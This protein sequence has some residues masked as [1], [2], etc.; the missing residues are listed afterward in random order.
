MV[1]CAVMRRGCTQRERESCLAHRLLSAQAPLAL[2]SVPRCSVRCNRVLRSPLSS[3]GQIAWWLSCARCAVWPAIRCIVEHGDSHASWTIAIVRTGQRRRTT[4]RLDG[5]ERWMEDGGRSAA[6]LCLTQRSPARL[7][8]L[9]SASLLLREALLTWSLR[10]WRAVSP[11][12]LALR[13]SIRCGSMV[14]QVCLAVASAFVSHAHARERA[15]PQTAIE[16]IWCGVW[17]RFV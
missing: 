16:S 5:A 15:V 2:H 13:R 8:G 6:G 17:L 11:P 1:H 7:A 10:C 3:A 14:G 4:K 9:R 12:S